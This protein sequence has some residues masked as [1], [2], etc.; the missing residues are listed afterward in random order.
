MLTGGYARRG[1]LRDRPGKSPKRRTT[2]RRGPL[3]R[4]I[5]VPLIPQKI[6]ARTSSI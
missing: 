6:L 3:Y 1:V 2:R 4:D 5:E